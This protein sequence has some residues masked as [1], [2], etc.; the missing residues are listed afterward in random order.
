MLRDLGFAFH[1]LSRPRRGRQRV[2]V[3]REMA[4]VFVTIKSSTKIMDK[5]Y[6]VDVVIFYYSANIL[7]QTF[8]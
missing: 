3:A 5:I 4:L 1:L 2:P 7:V 6:V 8:K